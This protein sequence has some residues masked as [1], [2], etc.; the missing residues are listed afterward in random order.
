V[1]TALRDEFPSRRIIV[2][3]QPHQASRTRTH[4]NEFAD[5]LKFAD[6]VFVPDIYLARDSEEDRRAVH[7]LDLVRTAANRGVDVRYVERFD[8]VAPQILAEIRVGDL[9]VTMGA[10]SVWEVSS[11]LA[12]RLSAFDH[13]VIAP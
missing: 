7:A 1:L 10:G 2:V 11:D 3:F 4:L 6:K 9:V 13:Q 5:A 8:E 12:D